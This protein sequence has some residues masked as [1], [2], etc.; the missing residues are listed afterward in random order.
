VLPFE[1]VEPVVGLTQDRWDV[2]LMGLGIVAFACGVLI[3]ERF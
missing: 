3:A 1:V 2:L